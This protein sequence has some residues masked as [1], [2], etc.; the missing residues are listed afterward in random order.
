MIYTLSTTCAKNL[1]KR[2]ILVQLTI[3]NVVTCCFGTQCSLSLFLF[4]LALWY[5]MYNTVIRDI[6]SSSYVT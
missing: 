2:T 3:K 6:L 5:C 4:S 1:C